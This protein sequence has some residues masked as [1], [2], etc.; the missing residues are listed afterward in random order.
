MSATKYYLTHERALELYL[1]SLRRRNFAPATLVS[2]GYHV[3]SFLAFVAKPVAQIGREDVRRHLAERSKTVTAEVMVADLDAIRASFRA[4]VEEEHLARD[5]TA[6]LS[7]RRPPK[8]VKLV[9]SE[10][11]VSRLFAEASTV[12]EWEER[13]GEHRLALALRN[14]A[15][16]ELL[17]ATGFRASELCATKVA[18]LALD[19]P[20]ILCRRA[21]RGVSRYLPLPKATVPH[22]ERYLKEARPLL[23]QRGPGLDEGRIFLTERGTPLG[24]VLFSTLVA[25]LGASVGIKA[26]PHAFRR[27]VATHLV[28]AGVPIAYVRELLGHVRLETTQRYVEVNRED[29]RK[30]VE[31]L[32]ADGVFRSRGRD[33]S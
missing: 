6:G 18:D 7:A 16:L 19:Q 8:Q 21:K 20:A 29:L 1:D 9:L 5:P 22:V 27:A 28:R 2:Q 30:A 10:K 25:T 3:R 17:Y 23:A 26:Y 15:A 12:R 32:E 11:A 14:R 31:L 33:A 24:P 4:L 13:P